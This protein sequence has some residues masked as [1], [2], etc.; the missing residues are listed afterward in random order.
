MTAEQATRTLNRLK[1][2]A[3]SCVCG[4]FLSAQNALHRN[5]LY[6]TLIYD[7]LQR[8]YDAV[9]Q[10]YQEAD[11]NWNQTFYLMYFR[12]LGDKKNQEAF[13]TLAR[14]VTYPMILRERLSLHAVESM[15]FGCS[16]LLDLYSNDEYTL[17][18]R[19]DFEYYAGK[20]KIEPMHTS[21]WNLER[22]HPTNHPVLRIAQAAVFFLQHEFVMDKSLCCCN[23]SDICQLF[24]TEASDYWRTHHIPGI[25]SG[26]TPK[27]IGQFKANLMGINLVAIMQYAY[28]SYISNESLRDRA[29]TLL[30]Q[31]P[32]EDN[33]YMKGWQAWG[34]TPHN[35]FESQ[36]LLQLATEYCAYR[37]C[38]TCPI[39][40][41][42]LAETSE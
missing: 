20:Y 39:G 24:C 12:T 11:T 19:R 1:A 37:R 28:G 3:A 17:N 34:L 15:L 38:E 40:H 14:R 27:R 10:L 8:K 36:A 29:I 23:L 9:H 7:R 41:R 22:I 26:A 35:A 16:G 21:E 18:L 13:L 31:L 33:T 6:T 4:E 25:T 30:E 5:E 32:P 2:G 42:R